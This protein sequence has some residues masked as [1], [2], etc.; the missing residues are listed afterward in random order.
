MTD[1]LNG[2]QGGIGRLY[3][4]TSSLGADVGRHLRGDYPADARAKWQLIVGVSLFMCQ[5]VAV[6]QCFD[7][8][9]RL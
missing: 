5:P 8:V 1:G 3:K 2:E 9:K 4:R 6:S 7:V